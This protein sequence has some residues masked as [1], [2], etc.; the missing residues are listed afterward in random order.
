MFYLGTLLQFRNR[1]PTCRLANLQYPMAPPHYRSMRGSRCSAEITDDLLDDVTDD[2]ARAMRIAPEHQ[3][4]TITSVDDLGDYLHSQAA[5]RYRWCQKSDADMGRA[6][7]A[8]ISG[9]SRQTLPIW[10]SASS[11]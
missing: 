9:S 6:L 1:K 2:L 11:G 10:F 3:L 5:R 8:L 4:P 7:P